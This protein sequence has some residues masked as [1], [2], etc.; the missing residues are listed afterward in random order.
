MLIAS[1]LFASRSIRLY[2]R[3]VCIGMIVRICA[4]AGVRPAIPRQTTPK[5]A[6]NIAIFRF[7]RFGWFMIFSPQRFMPIL[8][9]LRFIFMTVLLQ[10]DSL[11]GI[12]A[13]KVKRNKWEEKLEW[14]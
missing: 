5:A 11:G 12:R 7:Q 6:K 13:A 3:R 4:R 9:T 1:D 2:P 10:V 14:H 8:F